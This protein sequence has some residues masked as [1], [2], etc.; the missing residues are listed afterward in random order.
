MDWYSGGIFFPVAWPTV[1]VQLFEVIVLF[2]EFLDLF[3]VELSLDVCI[4]CT[5]CVCAV[6]KHISVAMIYTNK[7]I[8]V[9]CVMP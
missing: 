6:K 7:L 5:Q 2:V 3:T 4:M 8:F 1:T 9:L